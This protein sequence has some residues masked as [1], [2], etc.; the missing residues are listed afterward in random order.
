MTWTEQLAPGARNPKTTLAAVLIVA[1]AIL[2]T[3]TAILDGN[4][5]TRPDWGLLVVSLISSAGFFL[6]RD[7]DKSTEESTR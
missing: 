2:S 1:S 5:A 6:C 4:P 7:A 3:V